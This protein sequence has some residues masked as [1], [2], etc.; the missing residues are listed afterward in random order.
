M[1]N[2]LKSLKLKCDDWE[3]KIQWMI[4]IG[5]DILVFNYYQHK[6]GDTLF[7]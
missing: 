2:L 1:F 7:Q 4:D 6:R 3:T 5:I